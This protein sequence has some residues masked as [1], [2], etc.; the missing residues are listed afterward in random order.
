MF[1]SLHHWPAVFR[2]LRSSQGHARSPRRARQRPILRCLPLEQ[3][4]DRLVL[5]AYHVT[6]L[7]DGVAGSL[8]DAITQANTHAGADSI[9]FQV[10]G[11]ILLNGTELPTITQDLT[12]TGPGADKLTVSGN[13]TSRIFTVD[14]GETVKISGLTIA[15]GNAGNEN[16][17]GLD[18]FGTLTV[19]NSVFSSNSATNGGG[20]ANESGGTATLR[21][22]TFTSNTA[23]SLGGGLA[24]ENGGTA[25]VSGSTFTSNTAVVQG[26]GLNNFGTATVRDS[27]FTSNSALGS[28]GGGTGGGLANGVTAT[29]SDC[30]FTSN[31][32]ALAGGG[33]TNSGTA[34]VRD[35]TFT[36]NSAGG[37]AASPPGLARRR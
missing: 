22:S 23:G 36:S 25:T 21:G 17:G 34:T 9:N 8:R 30:T 11:T 16:G 13:N 6:T 12:I 29:V 3:L 15:G 10:T 24:N 4:E 28:S 26:G 31:S 32:A 7:T 20:L 19:S 27:A 5:T 37:A 1:R 14:A 33:I 2:A 18:N 35:C